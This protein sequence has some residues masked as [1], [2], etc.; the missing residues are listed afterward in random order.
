MKIDNDLLAELGLAA[1]SEDE[2]K[3]LIEQIIEDRK[4]VV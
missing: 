4:S 3:A 2:K 1:L